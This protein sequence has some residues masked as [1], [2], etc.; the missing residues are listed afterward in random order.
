MGLI[1]AFPDQGSSAILFVYPEQL[2]A[3]KMA[4]FVSKCV[5]NHGAG[6][7]THATAS[8]HPPWNSTPRFAPAL[9][10]KAIPRILSSLEELEMEMKIVSS[11][12][13]HWW[14]LG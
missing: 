1:S 4:V 7:H 12:G 3:E 6:P 14:G 11:A 10:V 8:R 9:S 13:M 5:V 2:P